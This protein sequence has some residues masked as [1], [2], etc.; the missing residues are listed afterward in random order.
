MFVRERPSSIY[1]ASKPVDRYAYR[2]QLAR[3]HFAKRGRILD[4][5]CGDGAWARWISDAIP[6]L[7]PHGVD[8]LDGCTHEIAFATYD[9][10]RLPYPDDHFDAAVV[11]SVL[12]H[13]LSPVA[14]VKEIARVLAIGARVIVIEDIASSRLQTWFTRLSDLY[15]N[16]VSNFW[17]ALTGRRKWELT[18]VPMTY[19]YRTYADWLATFAAHDLAVLETRSLPMLAIEHGVF[20]LE[21]RA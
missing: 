3:Q 13:A 21:K 1:M 2:V 19:E 15:G 12:H 11:F 5:G 7:E 18:Q 9:G 20:V 16:R 17:R 14:L 10:A 4:V 6:G 8:V